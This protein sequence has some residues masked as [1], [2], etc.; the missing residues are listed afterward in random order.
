MI[1]ETEESTSS[2]S[3]ELEM[4]GEEEIRK[5]IVKLK[6]FA[7]QTD[8]LLEG[9]DFKEIE[10]VVSKLEEIHGK[11]SNLIL[12]FEEINIEAGKSAR[13]VRQWKKEIKEK[14][15]GQL[16]DKERLVTALRER[17]KQDKEKESRSKEREFNLQ[18]KRFLEQQELQAEFERKLSEEKFQREQQILEHRMKAKLRLTERKLELEAE[19]KTTYSKLPELRVTQF[20]GTRLDW[21]R[22]ENMFTTQVLNKGFSDEIKFGYLLEMVNSKVREQIANLKPSTEGLK[23]AWDRLKTEYGQKQTVINTHIDEVV[24]LPVIRSTSYTKI[25]DFYEKLSRNYDALLT[26][27]EKEILKGFVM[28]TLNKLQAIK[29]DLVRTDEKWETWQMNNLIE[30]IYAWLRRNK[31]DESAKETERKEKHWYAGNSNRERRKP[32]CIFCDAE[33]W[34]DKCDKYESTEK[35]KQHFRENKLCFNCGKKG[36]Q[37]GKCF[38][39]GCYH[40]KAKHHTSLCDKENKGSVLTGFSPSVEETLPPIIPVVSNGETLWGFLD[41][42]SGRNFISTDAIKM[43]KLR[44]VRYETRNI[45]TVNGTKKQSLPVY[46]VTLNSVNKKESEEIEVTGVNLKDFTTITRPN[47]KELKT[48]FEHTKDKVYYMTSSG[49]YAIHLIL[50][51]KFYS[52]IK[53]KDIFKGKP[54]EPIVEG[55]TFGWVIHGG[56]FPDNQCMF[57]RETSDYERLY[58]LDVLGVEDR[59]ENDQLDV[60]REFHENISRKDDG[61]YEVNVPWVPGANLNKTNE[62]QSRK[63]LQNL[64][65]KLEKNESLKKGYEKIIDD[66]LKMEIIEKVPEKATGDRLYY[67]PHKPVVREDATTTKIRMVFDASAQP[68]PSSNSINDCMYKGLAIQPQLWDILIRARMSPY[69]ILGDVEKAFLQVGIKSED[70]DAFRFLFKLNGK[71]EHLRFQRVPFGTEASSFMLGATLMYHYGQYDSPELEDTINMLRENTYVDKLMGTGWSYESL[72]KF[73]IQSTAILADAKFPVHKWESNLTELESEKMKNPSG[74][75]GLSWDKKEDTLEIEINK[76]K[77]KMPVTKATMLSQLSRIYDPLG[78]VSPTLVEGKRLYREACDEMKSWNTELSKPLAKCYLKWVDQ[79]KNVK[80]PRSLIKEIRKVKGI[81]L[82]IFADASTVACSSVT[83]VVIQHETGTVKG[84]LTSKS[85]ISKRNTSIARLELVSGQ[86]AANMAKN[87]YNALKGLPITSVNIWMDSMVAL[88]W[89]TNPG[90]SWKVFVANR[91]RKIAEITEKLDINWRYCPTKSNIA[92]LGSRGANL[93]KM[94]KGEWFEGPNWVLSEKEW[95]EQPELMCCTTAN[96]EFKQMKEAVFHTTEVISDEWDNLLERKPYWQTLKITAWALRFIR[97]CLA[98]VKKRKLTKGKLTTEEFLD[99]RDHW[100]K[101]EQSKITEIKE[102]PGYKVEKE[103][104]TGILKC[105]G[106][107]KGYNPTYLEMG[108][109]VEKLITHT[110]QEIMHFGVADTMAA[111]RENWWIPRPRAAVKRDRKR[112]AICKVFSTKPY[113]GQTTAPLPLFRMNISWPFETT[114]VD[115]AGPF[116]YRVAK[117]K[118]EKAY[119]IIFTCAVMRGVHFEVTRTQGA[120]EFKVK[121]NA[122]ITRKTRP[123]LLVSDN[124]QVFKTTA[125]WIKNIRKSESVQDYLAKQ[126]ISWRFNLSKSPWWGSMYERLIK[127]LKRAI[128]K[129]VGKLLLSFEQFETVVMDIERHMNNRPLTYVEGDNEESQVLTPSMIMWGKNCHILEE[130][131]MDESNYTKI[132]RRLRN[133]REHVWQRWKREYLHS[134]MGIHRI[135]KTNSCIPEIGEIVL[136][137]GE[138]KNRGKWKKGKVIKL[139]KGRDGVVRGVTLLHKGHTIERPLQAVCPLE[140][141]SV[142]DEKGKEEVMT[143]RNLEKRQ[144]RNSAMNAVMKTKIIL[145]DNDS[146]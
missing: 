130:E 71:E 83:I 49:K 116:L 17:E 5:E 99:A 141:R 142:T 114:G 14:F 41:S 98:R 81:S 44:P 123:K 119:I 90:K 103:K 115:F 101:R 104:E 62:V 138:E 39:R 113:K 89:I 94:A 75:L 32:K 124:A 24:N 67:M 97:N 140:I 54:E 109:F 87:V 65:R 9:E 118:A 68:D 4:S 42:G 96:S 100:V 55:T 26:L 7:D 2:S 133:A 36:H 126:E 95:P 136:I 56:D 91:T 107:V 46:K 19:A 73:K 34:S 21:V 125:N 35:R 3:D 72:Q 129:T 77:E 61:R 10:V 127:D 74:I 86:M 47:L 131:D 117:N 25:H 135:T 76:A 11:I 78:I 58:S 122:F 121:L 53:T 84:L 120:D 80:V 88:F 27:G 1:R 112:C 28:T 132:Q 40:C 102:T 12:Q 23:I 8:E 85:R 59:G 69:I 13:A 37:E 79:L 110:H 18:T 108:L 6:Y 20:K 22:F 57:T 144:K 38:S 50:G 52:K 33:H 66:Q 63:R 82:H 51:D 139:V 16:H 70:R 30:S 45:L 29:S 43:L 145:E 106:R 143:E 134:L 31:V 60:M 15:V 128:Y 48:K 92:D 137:T 105:Y 64:E 146:D 111:I 93:E